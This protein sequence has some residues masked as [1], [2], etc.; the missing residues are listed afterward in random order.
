MKIF[1]K[2]CAQKL[3]HL[4]ARVNYLPEVIA[5]TI[6]YLVD[7]I[8]TYMYVFQ[9]LLHHSPLPQHHSDNAYAI[10]TGIHI[11]ITIDLVWL[12][13]FSRL[14]CYILVYFF[15]CLDQNI[16]SQD[17]VNFRG[18]FM[19]WYNVSRAGI[20]QVISQMLFDSRDFWFQWFPGIKLVTWLQF[21]YFDF[22][23]TCVVQNHEKRNKRERYSCSCL[24]MMFVH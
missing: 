11:L 10:I 20:I 24:A 2:H 19:Y 13:L 18:N 15:R 7:I 14:K 8:C 21:A 4:H 3:S 17:V 1:I 5:G 12:Y 22:H 6:M 23:I 9:T 16:S